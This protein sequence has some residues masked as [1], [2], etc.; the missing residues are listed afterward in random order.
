M[1][2]PW[3]EIDH[4]AIAWNV[5]TLRRRL[6]PGAR[7]LVAVKSGGYGH[8]CAEVARTALRHGAFALGVARLEEGIELREAGIGAPI[9]VF[10]ATPADG[11]GEL[12]RHQLT[13]TVSGATHARSLAAALP[14]DARLPVHL[15][16]D[17][18]MGR[19][20]LP[21]HDAP[22]VES[23]ADEAAAIAA[24]PRLRL[25]GAFTHFA[26]SDDAAGDFT[27][28]Q[29]ERF[30]SALAAMARHGV[31]PALRHAANS[32]A[33]LA[34]PDTHYDLVRAGIAVY[35]LAVP[36]AHGLRPAMTLKTRIVQLQAVPA[37]AT[38]GYGSTHRTAAPTVIATVAIGYGDGYS[39]AH[40]GRGRMLV[41]GRSVPLVG[42]VCMDLCM[43]D[44][45]AIPGVAL[46]DEVVVFGRQDGA[47]IGADDIAASIG[48]IP[49]ET[50]T[51]LT[52]RVQR[53]HR[54]AAT[55]ALP[56][57]AA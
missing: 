11:A 43:L 57:V 5:A 44:V 38:I 54:D 22:A 28:L 1:S 6:A 8:G 37:G 33:I 36:R 45:G 34:H 13:A 3:A 9:L 48:S 19:L 50:V 42:R 23:A 14:G 29:H 40:S 52:P 10:G 17:S 51:A 49:Y 46:G 12:L 32:A 55:I 2:S 31:R 25:Q 21:L 41:H 7:L 27:A 53:I 39:R 26:S 20:G 47:E 18:G 15:K 16:L 30:R 4:G 24:L 56:A 35:G